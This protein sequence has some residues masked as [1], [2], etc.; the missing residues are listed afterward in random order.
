V[1]ALAV[2]GLLLFVIEGASNKHHLWRLTKRMIRA[3]FVRA[4]SK[5]WPMLPQSLVSGLAAMEIAADEH[6]ELGLINMSEMQCLIEL[7]AESQR[8]AYLSLKMQGEVR[9][10]LAMAAWKTLLR[11]T[12]PS[13]WPRAYSAMKGMHMIMEIAHSDATAKIEINIY[14]VSQGARKETV[15]SK[16]ERKKALKK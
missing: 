16:K 10:Q 6:I 8:R 12:P 14:K 4:R 15:S 7:T 5:G 2:Q 1:F 3:V 11:N 13:Q 9:S